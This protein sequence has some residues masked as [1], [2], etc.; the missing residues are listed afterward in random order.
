MHEYLIVSLSIY[1]NTVK[2]KNVLKNTCY[3]TVSM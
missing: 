3:N 1:K 2:M